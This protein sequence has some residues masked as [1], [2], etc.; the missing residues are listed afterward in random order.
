MNVG[1]RI[2]DKS[3]PNTIGP[4]AMIPDMLIKP[5][6]ALAI[7]LAAALPARA[8]GL[9]G[10]WPE[11]ARQLIGK[12]L[13]TSYARALLDT[14]ALS[15]RKDGDSA[16]LQKKALDDA[17]LVAR[18]GALLQRYALQ[19]MK[20]LDEN[21]DRAAYQAALSASAGPKAAAEIERLKRDPNVK[22]FIT[23][24]QPAQLAR[25]ID[26][27]LEQ[28]DRYVLLGRIKLDPIA[29]I[30]RGELDG[31]P[32]EAMRANPTPAAEAAVERFL[33]EHPSPKVDRYLD[34][35][36][37]VRAAM[38]KG[39]SPQVALKLGPSVYFAGAERDLAELC[40]GRR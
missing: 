26:V 17:A 16:C 27:I 14:F 38:L 36:A 19:T 33:D 11:P 12:A 20:I 32:T 39:F 21:L 10:P 18:G 30:A 1:A 23:L 15:V 35:T 40:I 3:S 31:S 25:L 37:A 29:P 4:D 2:R 13:E 9:L 7:A 5:L 24:N 28:F 22:K 6:L 34:L 8:Q